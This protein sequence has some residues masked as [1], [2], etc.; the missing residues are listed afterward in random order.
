MKRALV[1]LYCVWL[2]AYITALALLDTLL[3]RETTAERKAR[4]A[5]YPDPYGN[6]ARDNLGQIETHIKFPG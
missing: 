3:L 2:L 4:M 6:R 1:Y 5:K